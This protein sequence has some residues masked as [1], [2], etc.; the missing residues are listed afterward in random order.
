MKTGTI[1]KKDRAVSIKTKSGAS[2]S[3]KF[4]TLAE[5]HRWLEEHELK[6]E[7]FIEKDDEDS[8]MMIRKLGNDGKELSLLRGAKIPNVSTLKEY[9]GCL[10]TC[11]RYSLLMAY[12]LASEDEDGI[13]SQ[14]SGGTIKDTKE[15]QGQMHNPSANNPVSEKQRHLIKQLC[16]RL[17]YSSTETLNQLSRIN[18]SLAA[19]KLISTLQEDLVKRVEDKNAK[20]DTV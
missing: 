2:Y 17:G 6:Y 7:A 9:G 15:K 13:D 1:L 19:S 12:G 10:T 5:I 16:D 18:N 3:Y 11:R 4:T 14:M 20:N 8:Y